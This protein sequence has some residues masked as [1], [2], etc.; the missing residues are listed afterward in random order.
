MAKSWRKQEK[1]S[2][3]KKK[4]FFFWY[5]DYRLDKEL[6]T[7]LQQIWICNFYNSINIVIYKFKI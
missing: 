2:F 4:I 7:I 3:P 5:F 1:K 6:S